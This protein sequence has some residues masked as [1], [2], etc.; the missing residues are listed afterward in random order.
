[1]KDSLHLLCLC[2]TTFRRNVFLVC[3]LRVIA[4]LL[5]VTKLTENIVLHLNT[6]FVEVQ[7]LDAEKLQTVQHLPSAVRY[8]KTEKLLVKQNETQSA[9]IN[10]LTAPLSPPS[11][12][13]SP[14]PPGTGK[15]HPRKAFVCCTTQQVPAPVLI[16]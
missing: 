4:T 5:G 3:C 13:A 6:T 14:Y 9:K 2:E 8:R 11:F 16:N 7:H 12:Y 1:M 10:L 15:R